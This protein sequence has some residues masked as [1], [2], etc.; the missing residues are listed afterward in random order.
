[1]KTQILFAF[2]LVVSPFTVLAQSGVSNLGALGTNFSMVIGNS[3]GGEVFEWSNSFTTGSNS[4]GYVLESVALSLDG[5]D[6]TGV[7]ASALGSPLLSLYKDELGVPG[8]LVTSASSFSLRYEGTEYFDYYDHYHFDSSIR[9]DPETTYWIRFSADG[10]NILDIA[11]YLWE[12]T[13]DVDEIDYGGDG[14]SIGD[15]PL[16]R[17]LVSSPEWTLPDWSAFDV[18]PDL[19]FIGMMD[20]R[21]SPIPEVKRFSSMLGFAISLCVLIG[22][23]RPA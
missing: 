22:R 23:R 14:W 5:F 9:I 20:I 16:F 12:A 19:A 4:G 17:A 10:A 11:H 3:I 18:D 2:T 15:E 7:E 13:H 21:A 1:M 8:D 6:Y